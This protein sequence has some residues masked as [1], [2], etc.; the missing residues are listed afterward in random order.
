MCIRDRRDEVREFLFKV[1]AEVLAISA[2]R[3]G[4]Q[5][6]ETLLLKKAATDLIWAASA[7]PNRTDRARVIADL[8]VLLQSLCTGMTLLGLGRPAQETHIKVCLLYTSR[9]V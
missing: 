2:V 3:Q 5:H 6:E 8:P 9:C 4:G 7:K 1:W